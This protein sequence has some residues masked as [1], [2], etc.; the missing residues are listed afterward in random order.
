MIVIFMACT[1]SEAEISETEINHPVYNIEIPEDFNVTEAGD[2][3][4]IWK[5]EDENLEFFLQA[6]TAGWVAIGIDPTNKMQDANFILAYVK[7]GQLFGSDDYGNG[8]LSHVSD[9]SLGGT[10]DLKL[11]NG[12]EEND[13]T[14]VHLSIPLDSEDPF[15]RPIVIG[16]EYKVIFAWGNGDNFNSIHRKIYSSMIIFE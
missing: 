2:M 14:L 8:L 11:I 3:D 6:P 10:V 16:E 12:W 15:D 9:E 1:E 7:N 13:N 4:F 5:I